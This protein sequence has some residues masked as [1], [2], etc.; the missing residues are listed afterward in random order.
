MAVVG[1]TNRG[2]MGSAEQV[3]ALR[4]WASSDWDRRGLD[5]RPREASVLSKDG[6]SRAPRGEELDGEEWGDD[7]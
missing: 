3:E 4:A 7:G 6:W 5:A 2:V 1:R